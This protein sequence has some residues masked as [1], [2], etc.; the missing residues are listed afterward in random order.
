MNYITDIKLR[1]NELFKTH[2]NMIIEIP[3]GTNEKFELVEPTFDRVECVRKVHGK[4][5]FYYGCF[6]E[7]YAGDKDPLDAILLTN[8]KYKQLD[9]VECRIVGVIHTIDA[10]FVDDK[11]LLVPCYEIME[12]D[13]LQ[14]KIRHTIKFLKK[15][16][17]FHSK[18]ILDSEVYG[19]DEARK[20]IH[21]AHTG[22]KS[23]LPKTNVSIS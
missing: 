5:P 22:Y 19:E 20:V 2:L 18:M 14:S 4:Y 3:T 6:P 13:D 23:R 12:D 21:L 15:Y 8:K 9:I 17:G 10:G 1:P 16:K 7:T 11:V